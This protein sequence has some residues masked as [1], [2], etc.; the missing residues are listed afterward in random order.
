MT[1]RN[2]I[3]KIG[4]AVFATAAIVCTVCVVA[5]FAFL[6]IKSAPAFAKIGFFQFLFGDEWIPDSTGTYADPRGTY[7]IFTMVVGTIAATAGALLIGGILGYFTAHRFRMMRAFLSC[8]SRL[9][10]SIFGGS[11]SF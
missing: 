10:I 6:I 8:S 7:G 1:A 2:K 4:K 9:Y 3:D 5:I 11:C